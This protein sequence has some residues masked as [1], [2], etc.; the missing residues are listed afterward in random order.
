MTTPDVP[1]RLEILVELPGTPDDVWDAIATGAGISAWF[2][3]TEVEEREGGALAIYMGD[4]SS[5]GT[6][7][8]W[9]P[10]R[11]FAYEEPDWNALA[12]HEG[13]P[14]TPMVSEFLV[15]AQSGGSCVLR[16]VTSAF[17]SGADWEQEFWEEM[18]KSWRPFFDNLRLYLSDFPGQRATQ[19]EVSS[20]FDGEPDAAVAAMRRALGADRAGSAVDGRGV[21]GTVHRDDPSGFVVRLAEPVPGFVSFSAFDNDGTSAMVAGWLFSAAAPAYVD[22]ERV[23]WQEWLDTLTVPAS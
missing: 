23:A 11:R 7:T 1:L 9:E 8:G 22:R 19:L 18:E 10:P 15:E 20:K 6:V 16:V 14:V 3:R 21:R 17:G 4:T 2:L 13:S 5:E 12:G